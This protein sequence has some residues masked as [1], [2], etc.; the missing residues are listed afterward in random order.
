MMI[1]EED[2][3]DDGDDTEDD[4]DDDGGDGDDELDLVGAHLSA[5]HPVRFAQDHTK[6]VVNLEPYHCNIFFSMYL[7]SLK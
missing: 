4:D 5:P 2:D 7:S 6:R 1:Y 3:E